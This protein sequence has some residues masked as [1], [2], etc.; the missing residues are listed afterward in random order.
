MSQYETRRTKVT[1]VRQGQAIC[2]E[3]AIEVEIV[4]EAAG[5]FLA[6]RQAGGSP[7]EIDPDQWPS[8]RQTID[9]LFSECRGLQ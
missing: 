8:L 4:D 1:V 7:I 3:S 2:D 9:E 6:M 5:E